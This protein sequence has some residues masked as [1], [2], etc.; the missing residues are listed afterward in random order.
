IAVAGLISTALVGVALFLAPR[1]V[2][3]DFIF[4]AGCAIVGWAGGAGPA[5]WVACASAA[6]LHYHE[7][8]FGT[9]P[10]WTVYI[11]STIRLAGYG[12]IAW[13]AGGAGRLTRNLERRVDDRTASLQSEVEKHR[14][15][16]DLLSEA[17]ELFRH[18]TENIADVFWVTDPEKKEIE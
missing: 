10:W 9:E 18:V 2:H 11:N 14:E 13:L 12:T 4:L 5:L 17:V 16:S 3:F 6:I 1:G 7:A 15:T 8:R